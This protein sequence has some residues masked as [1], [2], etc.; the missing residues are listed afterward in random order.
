MYTV[1]ISLRV[2]V[3]RALNLIDKRVFTIIYLPATVSD[4]S[5][6]FAQVSTN[7]TQGEENDQVQFEYSDEKIK[8]NTEIRS[9]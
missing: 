3:P 2:V 6:F 4:I 5:G 1:H 7:M 8:T 9:R